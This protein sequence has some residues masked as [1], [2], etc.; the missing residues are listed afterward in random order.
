MRKNGG[1][2][3]APKNE[4]GV[5]AMVLATTS[6]RSRIFFV[7]NRV[8]P[9]ANRRRI[10]VVGFLRSWPCDG[11]GGGMSTRTVAESVRTSGHANA[12]TKVK[13]GALNQIQ[14]YLYENVDRVAR[15]RFEAKR[16]V[17]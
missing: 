11:E 1:I 8:R 15:E 16:R 13:R 17:H 9:R 5:R 10:P 12:M 4:I 6:L 7:K 2:T 14:K 3:A